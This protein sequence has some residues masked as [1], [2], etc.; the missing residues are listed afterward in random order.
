[1]ADDRIWTEEELAR[2][3]PEADRRFVLRREVA[4]RHR[5]QLGV[6]HGRDRLE[7]RY[8]SSIRF[9]AQA[10]QQID[11][12]RVQRSSTLRAIGGFFLDGAAAVDVEGRVVLGQRLIRSVDAEGVGAS[13]RTQRKRGQERRPLQDFPA[14]HCSLPM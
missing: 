7:Q 3:I 8:R 5:L 10:G 13:R 6:I 12:L 11:Q 9:T 4:Q 1:M 14:A 2:L